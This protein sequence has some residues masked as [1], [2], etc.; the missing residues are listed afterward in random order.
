MEHNFCSIPI[1]WD[2]RQHYERIKPAWP[3]S[4]V[5]SSQLQQRV[6]WARSL[7]TPPRSLEDSFWGIPRFGLQT[8]RHLLW[9]RTVVLSAWA[10]L[11]HLGKPSWFS[12]P[13]ETSLRRWE[14]GLQKLIASGT[15]PVSGLQL[16]PGGMS[17]CQISV[18]LPYKRR[19]CLQRVIRPLKLSK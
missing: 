15:G 5:P 8:S 7:R 6:T 3:R 4:P 16:L 9:Q 2:L 10:L 18:H 13:F 14:C 12:D 17:Q 19:A 11:K 1:A